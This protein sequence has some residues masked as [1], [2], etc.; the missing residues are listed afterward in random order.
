MSGLELAATA[1]RQAPALPPGSCPGYKIQVPQ[2][3]Y[4][5]QDPV[6]GK[7]GTQTFIDLKGQVFVTRDL[8]GRGSIFWG[9]GRL[10][11]FND[12]TGGIEQEDLITAIALNQFIA[13]LSTLG[14]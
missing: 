14:F 1:R 10:K 7:E 2:A 9:M 6:T 13:E 8:V 4:S 3:G 11:K 12:V 5:R